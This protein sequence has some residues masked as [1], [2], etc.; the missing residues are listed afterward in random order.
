MS[1][2]APECLSNLYLPRD[3]VVT[4]GIGPL[5]VRVRLNDSTYLA[6]SSTAHTLMIK[7]A[8]TH[9][10]S[11]VC[12]IIMIYLCLLL[13]PHRALSPFSPRRVTHWLY[14]CAMSL[15]LHTAAVQSILFSMPVFMNKGCPRFHFARYVEALSSEKCGREQ[16][17]WRRC[18][19]WEFIV[20]EATGVGSDRT[21][22]QPH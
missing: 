22:E 14:M 1:P 16:T 15:W 8:Q 19:K 3:L 18:R 4:M 12:I 17:S 20:L 21:M 6:S 13:L 11:H 7:S 9:T 10:H 2:S 5:I